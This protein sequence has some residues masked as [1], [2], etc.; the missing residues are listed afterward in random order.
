MY[1]ITLSDS[2]SILH[3]IRIIYDKN[4]TSDGDLNLYLNFRWLKKYSA[5]RIVL[6]KEFI[7]C[8]IWR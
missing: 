7:L 8:I 3:L 6:N 1:L 2:S 5:E 4:I